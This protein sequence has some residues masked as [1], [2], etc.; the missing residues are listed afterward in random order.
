[1]G[2]KAIYAAAGKATKVNARR[3]V[4]SAPH[5]RSLR[6][7]GRAALKRKPVSFTGIQARAVGRGF[8]KAVDQGGLNVYACSVLPEHVHLV[9]AE[10]KHSPK[11]IVG[12]FKREATLRLTA[13]QLHPFQAEFAASGILPT[14]WG[15]RGRI[16][17][18]DSVDDVHRSIR[19]VEE[20]PVKEGKPP[21]VW[22][23]VVSFD[24]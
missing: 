4:A 13:E 21:Q 24:F 8:G 11:R 12:H 18:L 14:C 23:F 5:D 20:N 1:M 17:F 2:S 3:S 10:G 22:S 9:A 19:Y 16:V 7:S 6:T 15:A